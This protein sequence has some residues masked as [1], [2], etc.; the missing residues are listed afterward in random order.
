MQWVV[1]P[2]LF[3]LVRELLRMSICAIIVDDLGMTKRLRAQSARSREVNARPIRSASELFFKGS[4][5]A[6]PIQRAGGFLFGL[7]F[8]AAGGIGFELGFSD[9]S[10]V[11]E[12]LSVVPIF[13]GLWVLRSA[14][15]RR[16]G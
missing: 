2:Y 6:S 8:L 16:T 14:S 9:H 5:D 11:D 12:V 13:L 10:V 4:I 15:R 1:R 7:V 3:Q